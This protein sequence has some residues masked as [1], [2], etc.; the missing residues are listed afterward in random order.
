MTYPKS[1]SSPLVAVVLVAFLVSACGGDTN[2]NTPTTDE[3]VSISDAG[4][5]VSDLSGDDAAVDMVTTIDLGMDTG[6]DVDQDADGGMNTFPTLADYLTCLDDVDCPV[7]LGD[8]VKTVNLNRPDSDG[9]TV[10]PIQTLFP[11]VA[12]G[13]GVCSRDCSLDATACDALSLRDASGDPIAFT[14]QVVTVGASAYPDPAPAYPFDSQI[15]PTA[16][17]SG[18][19]FGAVCRPPFELN[20]AHIADFCGECDLTQGCGGTGVCWRFATDQPVSGDETGLCLEPVPTL[21]CPMGFEERALT[22][23]TDALGTFCVPIAETCGACQD[24]DGDGRGAGHCDNLET[25]CD[26]R[27]AVAYYDST[28]SEHAFPANCGSFDYNCNGLSDDSEQVGNPIYGGDHCEFCYDDADGTTIQTGTAAE[29]RLACTNGMISVGQCTD[30]NQVH[31]VGDARTAGCESTADVGGITYYIDADSDTFGDPG[32]PSLG[33]P[34]A[35]APTGYVEN[36]QDCNDNDFDV[37]PGVSDRC[38]CWGDCATAR[39]DNDCDGQIDEDVTTYAWYPDGD[40]DGSPDAMTANPTT[41]YCGAPMPGMVIGTPTGTQADCRDD[42]ATVRGAGRTRV[43]AGMSQPPLVYPYTTN[44]V[45]ARTMA[46]ELYLANDASAATEVC[47]LVDNNCNGSIDEGVKTTFYRD[48]DGDGFGD[49]ATATQACA[50]AMLAAP[51]NWVTVGGDC[52]PGNSAAHPCDVMVNPTCP[53]EICDG[54][55]NDCSGGADSVGLVGTGDSCTATTGNPTGACQLGT[56]TVCAMGSWTCAP[57]LA[58]SFDDPMTTAL[59]DD[60]DGPETIIYVDGAVGVNAPAS[61][62]APG[63]PLRTLAAALARPGVTEIRVAAGS[64]TLDELDGGVYEMKLGSTNAVDVIGGW[65][66]PGAG[67]AWTWN[68]GVSSITRPSGPLT[69][70]DLAERRTMAIQAKDVPAGTTLAYLDITVEAVATLQGTDRSGFDHY[71]IH[72]VNSPLTLHAVEIT[73]PTVLDGASDAMTVH[74]NDRNGEDGIATGNSPYKDSFVGTGVKQ[75]LT[76]TFPTTIAVDGGTGSA[77]YNVAGTTGRGYSGG[78]GG[79]WWNGYN[80]NDGLT[81]SHYGSAGIVQARGTCS[82]NVASARFEESR[83]VNDFWRSDQVLTGTAHGCNGSGGGGGGTVTNGRQGGGGGSGGCGGYRG[84]NG[85][86]GGSSFGVFAVQSNIQFTGVVAIESGAGGDGGGGLYGSAGGD[87]GGGASCYYSNNNDYYGCV[88]GGTGSAGN[89]GHGGAGGNGGSSFPIFSRGFDLCS[90]LGNVTLTLPTNTNPGG[91]GGA[92]SRGGRGGRGDYFRTVGGAQIL[93]Y[94]GG[95]PG[96]D[97]LAGG[98]GAYGTCFVSTPCPT[99]QCRSSAE[100]CRGDGWCYPISKPKPGL[101]TGY[102][103]LLTQTV[104]PTCVT[105]NFPQPF[106]VANED[107]RVVV[108]SDQ[109]YVNNNGSAG[110]EMVTWAENVTETGFKLCVAEHISK[111]GA[112]REQHLAWIAFTDDG[113]RDAGF[114]GG[115]GPFPNVSTSENYPICQDLNL[116]AAGFGTPPV[117]LFS[118][119]Y[120]RQINRP[121]T[122]V[123]GETLSATKAVYCART[124]NTPNPTDLRVDWLAFNPSSPPNGFRGG[125]V[126]FASAGA[127]WNTNVVCTNVNVGCSSSSCDVGAMLT[128]VSDERPPSSCATWAGSNPVFHRYQDGNQTLTNYC[129]NSSWLS[130]WTGSANADGTK[131]VCA[132]TDAG[133]T[134]SAATTLNW[135]A[136]ITYGSK[137]VASS[138]PPTMQCGKTYNETLTVRNTG[139]LNWTNAG[140]FKL[141]QMLPT[142]PER[143]WQGTTFPGL[144]SRI[145]VPTNINVARGGEYAFPLTLQAPAMA[146]TYTIEARMVQEFVRWFGESVKSTVVVTCP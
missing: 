94:A 3:D 96:L 67:N 141:G 124:K 140:A 87:G 17:V 19:S 102:E 108:S 68:N 132:A 57:R 136:P 90:D 7:G 134:G 138:I 107:V 69:A 2:S 128:S 113:A 118:G 114:V 29:A 28:D 129:M 8:C 48:T 103:V 4:A 45:P 115:R 39:V 123:W 133:S 80:I 120:P 60:C 53:A 62:T 74:P 59:D 131:M 127:A 42:L 119:S 6:A 97:G 61:G 81:W 125:R 40:A 121:R 98:D 65:T 137:I 51:A 20:E 85:G 12:S 112:H 104:S 126:N 18:P 32:F 58:S 109:G 78:L 116:S 144:T 23:G 35:G 54:L 41:L 100:E 135:V 1:I 13:E 142:S 47:D 56:Q 75:C 111:D 63:L 139:F 82:D 88:G 93:G 86:S 84:I 21:G 25:D 22:E 66:N 33:C 64:Y 14:C 16:M 24:R 73:A 30:A 79:V 76:N 71:G 130:S 10:V 110:D 91:A 95:D 49:P 143:L 117:I 122:Y 145:N 55:D 101:Q 15:D 72:A 44:A 89:G 70:V 146:G 106:G 11:N 36:D 9:T 105:V 52:V 5:D 83:I 99:G 46:G 26:D 27:N 92:P 31:C 77:V 38:D 37:K 50:A 34:N 43:L